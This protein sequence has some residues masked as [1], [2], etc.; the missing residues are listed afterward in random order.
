LFGAPVCKI[1]CGD[2]ILADVEGVKRLGEVLGLRQELPV[3]TTY[4]KNRKEEA[5]VNP[6]FWFRKYALVVITFVVVNVLASVDELFKF[7]GLDV[8]GDGAETREEQRCVLSA[9]CRASCREI[10]ALREVASN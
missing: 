3:D 9:D 7:P 1:A 5:N 4:M 8:E 2:V 6:E 10:G